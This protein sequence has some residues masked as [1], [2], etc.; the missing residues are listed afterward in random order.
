MYQPNLHFHFTGIGGSGMSGIAE[1][2]LCSGFRVSGSD[3][4]CGD[5]CDRLEK[6]GAQ[7]YSGHDEANVADDASL[8]VYSSAVSQ[9]NP[10]L[11][12]ARK[13]GLPVIRRA[14][15]LAE[16]MRL[17]YGVAVAGSHGKTTTTSMIAAVLEAGGLDPTVIIGGQV[18]SLGSGSKAGKS[19]YLVAEA[20]ESDRSF[21]LL[22]PTVAV[23]TNIDAEHLIAYSSLHEL[24]QS[25]EQF[26]RAVPF[27]GLAVLCADDPKLVSIANSLSGRVVSYGV[28]PT[29]DLRGV[30]FEYTKQA[31]SC[32]VYRG[33]ELLFRLTM[34][35]LGD[36]LLINSLA[37]VAVGLE[38]GVDPA[39]IERALNGFSG[40]ARRLEV[41]SEQ[42]GVTVINDYAHHPTEIKATL[43]AIKLAWAA[44]QGRLI[45]VFQPHRYSRTRD[46][47]F[48]FLDAFDQGDHLYITDIYPAGEEPIPGVTSE[49]LCAAVKQPNK[50]HVPQ[51]ETLLGTLPG[52]LVAGDVVACL[53]AGSIGVFSK[54]LAEELAKAHQQ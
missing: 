30:N 14:E 2:L 43:K 5:V 18:K 26:I 39:T 22:K 29:A 6:L 49:A 31:T 23:V 48:A 45:V 19:D 41:V 33:E 38:F 13:R 37:A 27:Y 36:H 7:I 16:L 54:N 46:C 53:G 52:Q 32:D 51:L 9:D 8:V 15:V 20:D 35:I 10:E 21:L 42:N 4:K 12:I 11:L 28:S 24:E 47:F 34:P 50:E 44:E 3:L 25:F 1:I 40:V 17:K